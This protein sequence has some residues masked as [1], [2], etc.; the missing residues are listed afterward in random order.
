M[1]STTINS[2]TVLICIECKI[3]LCNPWVLG[4]FQKSLQID[5][6]P[7]GR[8]SAIYAE[9]YYSTNKKKHCVFRR[10]AS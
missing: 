9:F 7:L 1:Y 6:F 5:R 2:F 8:R 10:T 3:Q 4:A